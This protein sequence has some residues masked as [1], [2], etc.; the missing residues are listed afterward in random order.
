M[1]EKA[2]RKM[3]QYCS[4]KCGMLAKVAKSKALIEKNAM[5][6]LVPTAKPAAQ[7]AN[8]KPAPHLAAFS[9]PGSSDFDFRDARYCPFG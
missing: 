5:Q 4:A 9:I 8:E 2:G 7:M 1:Y 6:A 3:S